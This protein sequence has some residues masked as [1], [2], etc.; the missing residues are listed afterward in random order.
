MESILS[1]NLLIVRYT[2]QLVMPALHLHDEQ[3]QIQ[4][5]HDHLKHLLKLEL[6]KSATKF[7]PPVIWL[8][9]NIIPD[10]S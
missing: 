10:I 4:L 3:W 2:Q 7:R 8:F 1:A 6:F 5:D 9:H